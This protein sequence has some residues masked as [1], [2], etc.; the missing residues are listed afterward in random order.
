MNLRNDRFR[1]GPIARR[2]T[3]VIG[4]IAQLD[5]ANRAGEGRWLRD[6]IWLVGWAYFS[7]GALD[8]ARETSEA[9]G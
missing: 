8:A 6:F 3:R 7:F 9:D 2:V 4:P 5:R 1:V